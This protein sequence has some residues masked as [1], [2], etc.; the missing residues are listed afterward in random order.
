M[1]VEGHTASTV[2]GEAARLSL[3]TTPSPELLLPPPRSSFAGRRHFHFL[4]LSLL[5]ENTH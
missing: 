4:V 1:N 2:H 5:A 3:R